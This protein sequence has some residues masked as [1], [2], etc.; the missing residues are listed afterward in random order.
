MDKLPW[1]GVAGSLDLR[2][3]FVIAFELSEAWG[4]ASSASVEGI[5]A[6]FVAAGQ[7]G[8]FPAPGVSPIASRLAPAAPMG[9]HETSLSFPLSATDVDGRACQ[10]LRHMTAR[11]DLGGPQ[12]TRIEIQRPGAGAAKMLAV[13]NDDNEAD[14]YPALLDAYRFA[15]EWVTDATAKRRRVVV[16][17]GAE[18][19]EKEIEA[20]KEP[21]GCWARL[22]ERSAF[23]LPLGMPDVLDN[24]MGQIALFDG[25]SAEIEVPVY[26]GSEMGWAVLLNLLEA[27]SPGIV[28]VEIE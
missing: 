21:V 2:G 13:V 15:V 20:L 22:L 3:Y 10:L 16:E 25:W 9:S 5:V 24:V 7:R 11:L 19:G 1:L 8:G 27:S 17:Y 12:V 4:E 23:A 26:R 28:R 18:I 14:A 6:D